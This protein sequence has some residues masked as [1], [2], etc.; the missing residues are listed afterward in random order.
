M[1]G[2]TVV[3]PVGPAPHHQQWL[4][5]C[6]DSMRAQTRQPNEVLLIDDMADLSPELVRHDAGWRVWRSPWRLDVPNAFNVGVGLAR[7]DLV[8]M[9]GADDWLEPNCLELCITAWEKNKNRDAYYYVGVR[10]TDGREDQT[11]PCNGAMVTKG[12]W[13]MTGG[14]P[15]E[16]ASGACDA[17]LISILM[18]HHPRLLIPVADGV[19]LYNYRVH[20][21]SDTGVRGGSW[22]GVILP[23]RDIL[24]RTW[25]QP[26]WGRM[27]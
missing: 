20:T 13:R 3:I 9:V 15:P 17:A 8:F 26:H 21:E 4:H 10:Y 11:V 2:I 12:L 22:Q 5:E 27:C 7:N 1:S 25:V 6:L 16:S 19:P 14:F 24:T 23:T 18:K